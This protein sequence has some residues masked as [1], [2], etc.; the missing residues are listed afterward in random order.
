M[1]CN[2]WSARDVQ[3]FEYVPLGPFGAKNFATSI[4]PWVV[5]ADAL[6]PFRC[7]TSAGEQTAPVPLPYLQDPTYSSYDLKLTVEIAPAAGGAPTVVS[8]SNYRHLYWTCKQQLVHHSVTG[9]DMRPADLLASG[10]ISGADATAFGSMLELCWQGTK[11]VGPLSDGTTRKFLKDGD[12]VTMRGVCAGD[13]YTIG[14]GECAGAVLP[15]GT[16]PPPLPAAPPRASL[17]DV[18]LHGY[19]RSSCSW[20]VRLALGFYGIDYETKAVNLLHGEQ[21]KVSALGQ[22]PKLEWCDGGGNAQSLTQSLAIIEFL[23][24]VCD[25][26]GMPSLLP[27]VPLLRARARQIAEVFNSGT[28]PLQNLSLIK[29]VKA[30]EVGGETVD[31]RALGKRAIEKGLAAAEELVAAGGGGGRYCV[32]AHLSLA[33]IVLIPQMYNAR[34]F[35]VDLA[36]YPTLCAVDAHCSALPVFAAA[37]PDAQPDAIK[38]TPPTVVSKPA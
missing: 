27:R 37:H 21:A 34:R 22:V 2:D 11:E 14:F 16:A 9:C 1:L 17:R 15:A 29:S 5:S 32:G 13:G 12:T 36:P 4:S 23:A 7:A 38:T 6:A 26:A 28:Q 25:A 8:T 31:G 20:R 24:D 10:T 18:T 33:D 30:A 35:D 19:W 3:K